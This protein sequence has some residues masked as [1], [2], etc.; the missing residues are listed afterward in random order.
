MIDLRFAWFAAG[1]AAAVLPA[2]SDKPAAVDASLPK[3]QAPVLG[4]VDFTKVFEVYPK[5][6]RERERLEALQNSFKGQIETLT[7]RIDERKLQIPLLPEGSR[8]REVKQ[9]EL[10]LAMQ[11]RTGLAKLLNEQLEMESLRMEVMLYEDAEIAIAK[12]AKDRGVQIVLRMAADIPDRRVDAKPKEWQLRA[13]TYERRQV[14]YAS[15]EVDLTPHVIKLMQ[16][17]IERPADKSAEKPGDA[18]GSSVP[19]GNGGN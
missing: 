8:E 1:F 18:P 15:A 6:I 2:Q 9:L 5:A 10:E 7:K 19:K 12:V 16:V 13:V 14:W 17:P 3:A 4:V 11:E